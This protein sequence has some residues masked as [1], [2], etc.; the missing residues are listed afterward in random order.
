[1][2]KPGALAKAVLPPGVLTQLGYTV[3][4]GTAVAVNLVICNRSPSAADVRVAI[5][6]KNAPT[7]E[8]W[9]EFDGSVAGN[10]PLQLTGLVM[11]AGERVFVSSTATCSA[12]LMG[13]EEKAARSGLFAKTALVPQVLTQLN[14][15]VPADTAGSAYLVICNRAATPADVR[16]ALTSRA[17]PGDDDWIEF[18]SSLAGNRPL[19]LTG[20]VLGEGEKVFVYAA[21]ANVS[22]RLMGFE[23]AAV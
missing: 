4:A 14:Y 2:A 11:G 17:V 20:L 13:F 21:G 12:R 1:M 9:I 7:D 18:D 5:T 8:D 6:D 22:A 10:R 16:V 19:H 23:E 15:V 3:P